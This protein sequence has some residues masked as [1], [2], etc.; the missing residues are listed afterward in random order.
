MLIVIYIDFVKVQYDDT[1]DWYVD[2]ECFGH[3]SNLLSY[4]Y[5]PFPP[6]II[7]TVLFPVVI[8]IGDDVYYYK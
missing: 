2:A 8:F 5:H 6:S 7:T 1:L 3:S 4:Q